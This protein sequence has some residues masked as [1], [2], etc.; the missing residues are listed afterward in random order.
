MQSD[1][2]VWC[3][4]TRDNDR[5]GADIPTWAHN[6]AYQVA[7][8]SNAQEVALGNN[9]ACVLKNDQTV[10]CWGRDQN[11]QLGR[12]K[13]NAGEG[14]VP[15][16]V[17][18]QN[19]GLDLNLY[20]EGVTQI[21]ISDALSCVAGD[22]EGVR[23]WGRG[24]FGSD[25]TESRGPFPVRVFTNSSH[26]TS[27]EAKNLRT[28][29][30][31]SEYGC[32]TDAFSLDYA[33]GFS[34][35]GTASP[36]SITVSGLAEGEQVKVYD[37]ENCAG[38]ALATASM[39]GDIDLNAQPGINR[40]Y[41]TRGNVQGAFSDCSKGYIRYTRDSVAPVI[42]N[43]VIRN[44]GYGPEDHLNIE[45]IFNEIIHITGSP[46][47]SVEG[48]GTANFLKSDGVNAIFR[49]T[50]TNDL[51]RSGLTIGPN[52]ELNGGTVKDSLG[53]S[54]VVPLALT[55]AS[56]PSVTVDSL[57][58]EI[59]VNAL[60]SLITSGVN[61]NVRSYPISGNCE[62]GLPVMVSISGARSM[63][64]LCENGTWSGNLNLSNITPHEVALIFSQRDA[65]D[66]IGQQE[67]TLAVGEFEQRIYYYDKVVV[68]PAG[69]CGIDAD[70]YV[71]CWGLN[72]FG[73]L[74]AGETSQG[75]SSASGNIRHPRRVIDVGE[76]EG[77]TNYLGNAVHIMATRG[78]SFL[79]NP[80]SAT[81]C[82]L[83]IVEGNGRV[84]CWGA[85]YP[86][87][88]TLGEDFRL[89]TV[90]SS[91]PIKVLDGNGGELDDVVFV[92]GGS[93]TSCA[94]K[95]NGR[96][97]C[98]GTHYEGALGI[99]PQDPNL[100]D[101]Q[102]YNDTREASAE[103]LV[104]EGEPLQGIVQLA[105]GGNVTCALS[106]QGEVY[107]WGKENQ[108]ALG[109]GESGSEIR[110]YAVKVVD[111]SAM[112][113][114]ALGNVVSIAGGNDG[115]VCAVH[116]DHT[117]SCW[118]RW[119]TEGAGFTNV[120]YPIQIKRFH[121]YNEALTALNTVHK[122]YIDPYIGDG[123]MIETDGVVRCWGRGEHGAIGN[124]S[125]SSIY[126][127]YY[128]ANP[129][130]LA[131]N[132]KQ[133]V[134][135]APGVPLRGVVG[136]HTEYSVRCASI[137]TGEFRCWGRNIYGALGDATTSDRSLAVSILSGSEANSEP[138]NK[139]RG[140]GRSGYHCRIGYGRCFIQGVN[141]K[142]SDGHYNPSSSANPQLEAVGLREGERVALYRDAACQAA[143][144]GASVQGSDADQ[145]ITL[146]NQSTTAATSIYFRVTGDPEKEDNACYD[147]A[148]L[149][150]RRPPSSFSATYR[151]TPEVTGNAPEINVSR[152]VN[153]SVTNADIGEELEI[154]LN[155]STCSG[156]P[157]RKAV[158]SNNY[159]LTFEWEGIASSYAQVPTTAAVDSIHVRVRNRARIYSDCHAATLE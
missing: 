14:S 18:A 51:Y 67:T 44:E 152:E 77:S 91:V 52:I 112:A 35:F 80:Y 37:N 127:R 12:G 40:Y 84:R 17:V 96:V 135:E 111:H 137:D 22:F 142:M 49:F 57:A 50:V 130:N 101:I 59:T 70:R 76:T 3:W 54:A 30:Y 131:L 65:L 29:Y 42:S 85:N 26:D 33:S 100:S 97:Y 99:G 46:Q 122:V 82:A 126:T 9:F 125:N 139:G 102:Q 155:D 124:G 120:G 104:A 138:F 107:C 28:S 123:C 73:G 69:G 89:Y 11:G 27:L 13:I 116:S 105:S 75:Y 68:S 95:S 38:T 151:V 31:C 2:T 24:N 144:G 83:V 36:V 10:W 43:V 16:Q 119:R 117:L 94:L 45:V 34:S 20:V 150:D 118:G 41:Y 133:K 8:I 6:Y 153:I 149:L 19:G 98:W 81:F 108:G 145:T 62:G 87:R 56:F 4:G 134:L 47:I 146:S 86:A 74:G 78:N 132:L 136:L 148:I 143:I 88:V 106:S 140:P 53:N 1:G 58:P 158:Y 110:Y 25:Y 15:R 79:N 90:Y 156:A 141:L 5:R 128:H 63:N 48:V 115:T 92:E 21:Q 109:N 121:G 129:L 103:V 7:G 60:P 66:N 71:Y 154:Y 39:D 55:V 157:E 147:S 64:F 114:S 32:T 113:A 93:L 159:Q 23:C 72:Y 61:S